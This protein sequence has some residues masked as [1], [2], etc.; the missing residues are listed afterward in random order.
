[1]ESKF[2]LLKKLLKERILVFDGAMGTLIQQHKLAEEDFRGERFKDFPN[3]LKGNNEILNLTQPEILRL[4]IM[5]EPQR[6]SSIRKTHLNPDLL[7]EV[8]GRPIKPFHFPLM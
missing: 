1:M 4:P 8:L 6:M 5:Q 3:D 2:N 7:R